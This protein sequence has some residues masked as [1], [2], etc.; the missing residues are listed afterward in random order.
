MGRSAGGPQPL[1]RGSARAVRHH[2]QS[3]LRRYLLDTVEGA[4]LGGDSTHLVVDFNFA[5]NPSRSYSPIWSG[6]L[7]APGNVVA[8]AVPVGE[9]TRG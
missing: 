6:P 2:P 3:P 4:D 7:P 8:A 1:V 5:Y 9:R